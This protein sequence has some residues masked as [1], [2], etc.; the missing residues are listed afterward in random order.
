MD[1]FMHQ[2]LAGLASGGTY[3]LLGLAAVM[4][5]QSTHHLNFAQGEMAMFSTYLAWTALQAGFSYPASFA[6]SVI[7]SFCGGVAIERFIIRRVHGRPQ[8]TV[9]ML[10]VAL[11]FIFNSLAALLFGYTPKTFPTP[12]AQIPA[13]GSYLS[14]HQLGSTLVTLLLMA[15][16]Y[17]F[18]AFTK[19]GLA[20]RASAFN[21][22]SAHLVGISVG[23]MSALGWGIAAVLGAVSGMMVAP[24][25]YLDPNMMG[26]VLIYGF[27][28]A[29]LGGLDSPWGAV[30]G[31]FL[32][33]AIENVVGTYLIGTELKL[34]VALALIV[35]VL[36]FR[37]QGL[38]GR[39]IVSRV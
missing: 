8:L 38:F 10:F 18:F 5:Y 28:A 24:A 20:I 4:I 37:P 34:S 31:G 11:L 15:A 32:V 29:L 27:A 39:K 7:V 21:P 35:V 13:I 17:W 9:V 19:L 12:F 33:G 2:V 3:A 6:I 22:K 1:G 16:L 30:L 36:I 25:V 26:G 14:P 23:S